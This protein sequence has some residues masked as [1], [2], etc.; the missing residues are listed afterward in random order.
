MP[1]RYILLYKLSDYFEDS[2][3]VEIERG[4]PS[5]KRHTI[6]VNSAKF[7]ENTSIINASDIPSLHIFS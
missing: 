1:F 4:V 2:W 3:V 6:K 7:K 5:G